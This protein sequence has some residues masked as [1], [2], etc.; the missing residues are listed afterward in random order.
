MSKLLFLAVVAG[1]AI[2]LVAQSPPPPPTPSVHAQDHQK[3][4]TS[5]QTTSS[6]TQPPAISPKERDKQSEDKGAEN[7]QRSTNRRIDF[8]AW[9]VAVAAV[10]QFIAM[11]SQSH[12]MRKGLRVTET[13]ANAAKESADTAAKATA[14]TEKITSITQRAIVL[15]EDV[16]LSTDHVKKESIVIFRL[17]NFGRTVAYKVLLKGECGSGIH[18]TNIEPQA[19]ATIAP[20]GTAEWVTKSLSYD[21]PLEELERIARRTLLLRFAVEATYSDVFGDYRYNARGRYEPGGGVKRFMIDGSSS[22]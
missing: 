18:S 13:A 7:G 12:Y 15:L 2:S 4:A 3:H 19:E 21:I 8:L 17:K 6:D 9:V 11:L 10:A 20:Q 1:L 22:D 14:L 16:E 5:E